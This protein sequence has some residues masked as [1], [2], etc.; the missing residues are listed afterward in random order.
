[1]L[2]MLQYSKLPCDT[3]L[4]PK[5]LEM[6]KLRIFSHV[7]CGAAIPLFVRHCVFCCLA[8][9]GLASQYPQS[10]IAISVISNICE[11]QYLW[12]PISA[13]SVIPPSRYYMVLEGFPLRYEWYSMFYTN[14]PQFL[15]FIFPYNSNCMKEETGEAVTYS[16]LQFYR[17]CSS[18]ASHILVLFQWATWK[19]I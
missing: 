19:L 11:I 13:I 15:Y 5:M 10:T 1:M 6:R 9:L 7:S 16:Y 17:L 12:Y 18:Y 8:P 4:V 2:Y 14:F 3:R